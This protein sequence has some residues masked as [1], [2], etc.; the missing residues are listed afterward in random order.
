MW[1]CAIYHRGLKSVAWWSLLTNSWECWA[2]QTKVEVSLT[3]RRRHKECVCVS[4][5]NDKNANNT[6]LQR[7][8]RKQ[9][10]TLFITH[11]TNT[12][13]VLCT[14]LYYVLRQ[15]RKTP[16][17]LISFKKNRLRKQ[18][19]K[20]QDNGV[21]VICCFCDRS[22]VSLCKMKVTI[23]K[24]KQLKTDLAFADVFIE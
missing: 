11:T 6:Q 14:V 19:F 1:T 2:T 7:K 22:C 20:P 16:K 12:Q 13:N 24:F 18:F 10:E 23:L 9:K 4:A 5:H 17:Q 15:S 8:W 3:L 21:Y